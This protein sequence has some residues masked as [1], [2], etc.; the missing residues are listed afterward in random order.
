MCQ[1][2]LVS[3]AVIVIAASIVLSFVVAAALVGGVFVR[4][5]RQQRRAKRMLATYNLRSGR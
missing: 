5:A 2:T 1:S 4:E 3:L